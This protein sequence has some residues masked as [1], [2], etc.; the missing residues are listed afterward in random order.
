MENWWPLVF[1]GGGLAGVGGLLWGYL[2]TRK[3]NSD[4]AKREREMTIAERFDDASDLAK[5]INDR[6]E[7]EVERKVA[8]IRKELETVKAES[9]EMNDAVRSNV[10]QQWLW[11]QRGRL[12]PLP[13]LPAPILERLGLGY[14]VARDEQ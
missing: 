1:G 14:F 7:A 6:V 10:T 9:H 12:G 11:D 8:P 2:G 5:Y 4:V 13:T 3:R